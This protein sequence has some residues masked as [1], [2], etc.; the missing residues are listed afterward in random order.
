M[1]R[2]R[3]IQKVRTWILGVG[4]SMGVV[5]IWGDGA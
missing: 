1:N 2:E 4:F 3:K 5:G